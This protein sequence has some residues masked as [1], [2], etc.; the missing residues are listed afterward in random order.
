VYHVAV[1]PYTDS[2]NIKTK[3][4]QVWIKGRKAIEEMEEHQRSINDPSPIHL[5]E[6]PSLAD[7]V[8]KPGTSNIS[9][10]GNAAF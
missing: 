5:I 2:I 3:N 4:H 10:P 7:V 1:L 8:F 9:H 6:C